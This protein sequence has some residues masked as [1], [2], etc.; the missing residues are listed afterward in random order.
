MSGFY[1]E[2]TFD[3]GAPQDEGAR[4]D[5]EAHL[6]DV[7]AA[8]CDLDVDGDVGADLAAGRI[9]LCMTL[10]AANR[11]DALTCAVSAA[12]TAIHAAGGATP[13]WEKMLTELLD[14]DM[15]SLRSEPSAWGKSSLCPA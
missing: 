11:M 8:F 15:Y 12:R 6:D 1:V 14:A 9:D 7:A 10:D 3:L 2:M 4:S 5:L 13:G